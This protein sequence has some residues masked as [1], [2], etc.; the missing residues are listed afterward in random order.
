MRLGRVA[1]AAGHQQQA[2]QLEGLPA[3]GVGHVA[4]HRAGGV[5]GYAGEGALQLLQ[6]LPGA[7]VL[8]V[9]VLPGDEAALLLTVQFATPLQHQ[10]VAGLLD[11]GGGDGRVAMGCHSA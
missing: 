6:A 1:A 7:L 8:G 9:G 10:P 2:E 4:Q 11:D 3:T 5:A